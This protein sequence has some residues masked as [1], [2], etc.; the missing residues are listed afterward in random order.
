MDKDL[1]W[2]RQ[3]KGFSM[4][5]LSVSLPL[6]AVLLLSLTVIFGW[7]IKSYFFMVSDWALQRDVQFSM[8]RICNDVMFADRVECD[9]GR[10]TIYGKTSDNKTTRVNY[11][12]TRENFPRIRRN[13]QPLTGE[14]SLGTIEIEEMDFDA[15]GEVGLYIHIKGR[16]RATGHEY[17]LRTV[18]YMMNNTRGG[19]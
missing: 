16:N 2:L 18:E 10:I 7:G 4:M 6:F 15:V 3:E 12:L 9:S 13:S 8:K 1:H 14:S 17:E 11:E 5:E 19:I